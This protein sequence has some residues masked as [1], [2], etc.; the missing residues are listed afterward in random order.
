MLFGV[1]VGFIAGTLALASARLGERTV[2]PRSY[3]VQLYSSFPA[4]APYVRAGLGTPQQELAL[5]VDTGS[6]LL[7][8]RSETESAC[9]EAA[10]SP[11]ASSSAEP[12]G[13]SAEFGYGS[14]VV[15]GPEYMDNVA[16]LPNA[17]GTAL[18]VGRL[19]VLAARADQGLRCQAGLLG[20]DMAS[21]SAK[22]I[23]EAL[24]VDHI[25]SILLDPVPYLP[26]GSLLEA[27]V[28]TLG[29]VDRAAYSGGLAC[30][31]ML[32]LENRVNASATDVN[33]QGVA[34]NNT[35][36]WQLELVGVRVGSVE[37]GPG[38]GIVDTGTSEMI[39]SPAVMAH[40][41]PLLSGLS[42][43]DVAAISSL[44]PVIFTLVGGLEVSVDPQQYLRP[45][46][47]QAPTKDCLVMSS[48]PDA[49]SDDFFVLGD[50]FFWKYYVAFD[51]GNQQVGFGL[52]AGEQGMPLPQTCGF[53]RAT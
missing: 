35:A 34:L 28:M 24:G 20:M 7:W 45:A 30:V 51:Y 19:E 31:S 44:P 29:G 50:P 53:A 10:Y 13:H 17:Q 6:P 39:V 43:L 11:S 22:H 26:R 8:A 33:P 52:K 5:L 37:F 3:S 32:P 16:F 23:F 2:K 46:L 40:F 41:K 21:T 15:R 12:L 27:G 1:F 42:C 18:A 49:P 48:L 4:F 14:G 9:W 38:Q 47:E 36:W 25:L